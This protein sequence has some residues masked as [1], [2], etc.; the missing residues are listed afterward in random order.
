MGC[1]NIQDA[2]VAADVTEGTSSSAPAGVSLQQAANVMLWAMKEAQS[3]D[4]LRSHLRSL[5]T[6]LEAIQI[7]ANENRRMAEEAKA[8]NQQ[9]K[10]KIESLGKLV[11]KQ[12]QVIVEHEGRL[13]AFSARTIGA[14]VASKNGSTGVKRRRLI[15][16]N[17][18]KE[19]EVQEELSKG[20]PMKDV[21]NASAEKD[22]VHQ[23][24]SKEGSDS[25]DTNDSKDMLVSEKATSKDL[26]DL[27]I[28]KQLKQV[29]G[30]RIWEP[31]QSSTKEF[32]PFGSGL[33][34]DKD[35]EGIGQ[36]RTDS[37]I[38]RS[39]SFEVRAEGHVAP[40]GKEG[41][42]CRC[43]VRGKAQRLALQGFDCEQCRNFYA[44]TKL[45][46]KSEDLKASRHRL[47]HAPTCT[48]PGFWDLSFPAH[49]DAATQVQP[50][51]N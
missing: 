32:E 31:R 18:P 19:P 21:T 4:G 42:P 3:C 30:L 38:K 51:Q 14:M 2:L 36:P 29:A 6:E 27:P 25:K 22:L 41:V 48:P 23:K 17:D 45:A 49:L 44:A 9:L 1:G 13:R 26:K 12:Q 28:L 8:E 10:A 35:I 43:V 16:L 33:K 20:I 15:S 47:E 46:P 39:G 37:E 24:R 11:A 5:Q 50:L 7:E 40:K 34:L